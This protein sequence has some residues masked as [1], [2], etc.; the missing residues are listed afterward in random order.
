MARPTILDLAQAAG[1]S[2]STV[3]RV[4]HDPA[5]VRETTRQAVFDAAVRTGFAGLG[6][7]RN[8]LYKARRKLRV[9][10][11]L[12]QRN[13]PFY[14]NLAAA[15]TEAAAQAREADL[16][17]RIDYQQDLSPDGTAAAMHLLAKASDALL[18]VSAEHPLV[19]RAIEDLHAAGTPVFALVSP[20][21]AGCPLGYVGLDHWKVGRTAAWAFD[22]LLDGPGKI[23]ILVGSHRYRNQET[24][25]AGFR[26]YFREYPRG[27]D[28]LEPRYTYE[29]AT[30]ARELTESLLRDHPDLAGLYISGGG[31]TGAVAAL[32]GYEMMD[33]TREALRDGTLNFVIAHPIQSMAR[34]AIA[35]LVAACEPEALPPRAV[36]LPFE[37]YTP[38][39]I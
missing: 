12:L 26:S 22:R 31:I 2:V 25:E 35:E 3:N 23:G 28:L 20:L 34:E 37:L 24:N 39:N 9:G 5:K 32:R 16:A 13:R 17:I 4:L 8:N 10:V 38:E 21:S 15:L 7:I 30:I 6:T 27:F 36:T 1:V 33:T 18:V 14:D 11:L 19:T 29:R